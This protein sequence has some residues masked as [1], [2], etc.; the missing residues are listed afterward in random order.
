M[1]ID[2]SYGKKFLKYII[3]RP[4]Q[5]RRDIFDY[6]L[7]E[8]KD[9]LNIFDRDE[10]NEAYQELHEFGPDAFKEFELAY[11]T[12]GPTSNVQGISEKIKKDFALNVVDEKIEALPMIGYQT[13]IRE[14][15]PLTF[16]AYEKLGGITRNMT[17]E[18]FL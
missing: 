3:E 13:K 2:P 4:E 17:A 18:E 8:Y 11:K 7:K 10:A 1:D 16:V 6:T 9:D 14:T 5:N 15:E 12:L